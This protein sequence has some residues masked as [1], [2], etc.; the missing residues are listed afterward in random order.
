VMDRVRKIA[1]A[2]LS[3][4]CYGRIATTWSQRTGFKLC[5]FRASD[6]QR[7]P[8]YHTNVMMSVGTSIAVICLEAI[9]SDEE[10]EM[11][12][13]SLSTHTI[14]PIT[15]EQTNQL[16]GNILEVQNKEGK[17]FMVMSARAYAAFTR[18]QI[19]TIMKH[20]DDIIK[21]NIDTIESIGGGGVR[22]MLGELF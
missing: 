11:V 15:R 2:I 13:K 4:R 18:E 10:R 17:R 14:V 12:I 8:I 1:Y 20:V 19:D 16:C 6:A 21:A 5:L 3:K 9:D 22:C 7:R